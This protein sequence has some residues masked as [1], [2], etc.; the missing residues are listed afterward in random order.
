MKA[1][2][3][4]STILTVSILFFQT[5]CQEKEKQVNTLVPEATNEVTI[6]Q[7]EVIEQKAE[8]REVAVEQAT[9]KKGPIL[10][11]EKRAHDI[12]IVGPSTKNTAEFKFT[13]T[14]DEVLKITKKPKSSC[15]C[16]V[17]RLTKK[18][19]AP[20][21]SGVIKVEYKSKKEAKKD[22]QTVTIFSNDKQNPRI[23]LT[24]KAE[25][26]L[27]VVA[28]PDP[29]KLELWEDNA[30][31][32]KITIRSKDGKPFSITK[33]SA[34]R[35]SVTI[36]FDPN[37]SGPGTGTSHPASSLRRDYRRFWRNGGNPQVRI[38]T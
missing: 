20:G 32:P 21:E 9:A 34:T 25:I 17:P 24:L 14:G 35:L 7:P 11:F 26:V 15:G 23:T 3:W 30:N 13:N 33:F 6:A 10:T 5:G 31:C 12:G 18:E 29:L 38:H 2:F 27:K 37:V 8:A 28:E 4:I 16:T 36:D 22:P 19:Y 1:K